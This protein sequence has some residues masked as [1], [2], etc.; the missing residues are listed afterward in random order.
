M[1][2]GI[3]GAIASTVVGGILSSK[4]Q[5]KQAQAQE[6]QAAE[7]RAI[8]E[9]QAAF[10]L[11][12]AEIEA[13]LTQEE[14]EDAYQA[15]L[16]NQAVARDNATW[17][18]EAGAV[19]LSQARTKWAAH[20]GSVTNALATSGFRLDGTASHVL[21]EQAAEA[22]KDYLNIRRTTE[23]Q[24]ARQQ[25]Q[26]TLFGKEGTRALDVA[27]RQVE[28]IRRGGEID[29]ESTRLTGNASARASMIAANAS[30]KGATTA[31][32][33]TGTRVL[34]HVTNDADV[35]GKLFGR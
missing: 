16:F 20:L 34:A 33:N 21:A 4:E 30:N 17:E 25:A 2:F 31:L 15:A 29:A 32:V 11:E 8:A 18:A 1:G 27:A 13:R 14:G 24:V 9:K 19:A 10:A 26:A 22:Q 6:A 35:M 12:M 23:N 7:A 5:K 3:I 28:A